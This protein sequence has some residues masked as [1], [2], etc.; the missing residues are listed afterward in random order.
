M[1]AIFEELRAALWSIWNR[2]WLALAVA[3]G[4]CCLGW[5]VV[6]LIPNTYESHARIFVQLDDALAAQVGIGTSAR[7]KEIERVTQT[8][9]GAVNLEKVIRSTRIGDEVK[10]DRDMDA[11]V[12]KLVEKI[13][14]KSTEDDLFEITAQSGRSD[15]SDGE[16]A[17][18]AQDIVQKLIDIFREDNLGS[19][20]GDMRDTINFLDQQLAERQKDLEAAELKQQD[21]E[22]QH[23]E[24]IGGAGAIAQ[25]LEN[26]RED[27]RSLEADLAAAQSSLAAVTGQL[28]GTPRTMTVPGQTGG[29]QGALLQAQSNLSDMR[30]RGLTDSH[31]DVIAIERQIASLQKQVAAQGP[32]AGGMPNPAYASLESIKAERQANV[33]ALQSRHAAL[34]SEINQFVANQEMEPG[35]A[36]EAQRISRD[37]DVLRKQ[38]DKLL[39]DREEL[40]LRGQV[41]N[42]RSS[43]KFNVIDPPTTPR[44][45]EA[46]NRPLLLLGVLVLGI[47][48]GCGAGWGMGQLRSSF[49]TAGKLETVFELPVI[50]T[51]SQVTTDAA[52]ALQLKRRKLFYAGAGGL[53]SLFLVLL[54][55]EFVQ[56]GMV[57]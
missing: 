49:A 57:A 39:Q 50:G 13:K 35:A 5:L 25:K 27:L 17:L 53:F 44:V 33:E 24:L 31:P 10:S 9:T 15:L 2:R 26:R 14:V 55:V 11:A 16:N 32:K 38:Y 54:A 18:L 34:Q 45:P 46:P 52:R 20:R 30:A 36:A 41:E 48:A 37:Y 22:S 42:E 23:P 29:A 7:K 6:A 3:W 1:N 8:L 56:R 21:F 47:A 43:V 28:G 12:A 51:I 4:V 40:R 19:S